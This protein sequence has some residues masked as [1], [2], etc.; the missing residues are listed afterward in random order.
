[1]FINWLIIKKTKLYNIELFPNK[2]TNNDNYIV[3]DQHLSTDDY[4]WDDNNH[5]GVFVIGYILPKLSFPGK[6][7]PKNIFKNYKSLKEK[8][9]LEYKGNFTL[10]IVQKNNIILVS[11]TFG[12]SK[13]FF[14][15]EILSN[16][17]WLFKDYSVL[18]VS[19]ESLY[20]YTIFNYW[21]KDYT[22]FEGLSKS[23]GGCYYFLNSEITKKKYFD[24][25]SYL[26]N[27]EIKF[28][29]IS[30]FDHAPDLWSDILGQYLNFFK[31][32]R[33]S[34]SLTAG[35]DSRMIL[36]GF[37]K[38]NFIP[39]AFTFGLNDS[40]DV[41]YAKKIAS[42]LNIPHSHFYPDSGFF[43][44]FYQKAKEVILEANSLTTIYRAHRFDAYKRLSDNSDVVF[45]GFIGS[46]I[47]RGGVYPDGLIYPNFV[48]DIWRG[49]RISIKDILKKNFIRI[50]DRTLS[51]VEQKIFDEFDFY[52]EPDT[53]IFE[54]IIPLHFG[55]DI[56]LLEKLGVSSVAPYWDIDFL[57][58][59]KSTPYFFKNS[60]KKEL[61]KL[62]HFKRRKGPIFSCK[63]IELLDPSNA[64]VSLGKGYTPH[65]FNISPNYAS[66]KF[67]YYKLFGNK[68]VGASNFNYGNW[69]YETLQKITDDY[70]AHFFDISNFEKKL[71]A[72]K[73]IEE[74]GLL[75]FTKHANISLI[76]KLIDE[77]NRK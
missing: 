39:D 19:L 57:D 14:N 8:S 30:T 70:K 41:H 11:D 54:V 5:E 47:I 72:E 27:R 50:D 43:K 22:L 55:Q 67:L 29:T 33:I 25:K 63:M 10:I 20:L 61:S 52:K 38:L 32:K 37:K 44:N 7:D 64:K 51:I 40:M 66:I 68:F 76:M 24:S 62:G 42:Q 16:N 26:R 34:Q 46:E 71:I 75:P 45:L 12:I 15:A 31:D 28:D 23:E 49:E 35:L 73:S 2:F 4:Y 74:L 36:A 65:D 59:Q 13:F 60:N 56:R 77:T 53:H 1:M 3:F 58:F 17:F 69:F 6:V 48:L 18:N 21:I 9:F